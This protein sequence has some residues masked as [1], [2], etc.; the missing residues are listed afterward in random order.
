MKTLKKCTIMLDGAVNLDQVLPLSTAFLSQFH[1]EMHSYAIEEIPDSMRC[2][3]RYFH[4]SEE[5]I[6]NVNRSFYELCYVNK[7]KPVKS[8]GRCNLVSLK[9]G[10]LVDF[11]SEK[12]E[13]EA[14]SILQSLYNEYPNFIPIRGYRAGI[15]IENMHFP[16]LP[17]HMQYGYVY[18]DYLNM[19]PLRLKQYVMHINNTLQTIDDTLVLW[20]YGISSQK[21]VLPSIQNTCFIGAID[22][23]LG[24][25][26]CMEIKVISTPVMSGSWDTDLSE[27]LNAT[28]KELMIEQHVI[29]HINGADEAAHHK[30]SILKLTFLHEVESIV[31]KPLCMFC[32]EHSIAIEI[33]IDHICDANTGMHHKGK[34]PFYYSK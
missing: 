5:D 9:N 15:L 2:Y 1:K 20:P 23:L 16:G 34:T 8:C 3:L 26:Q 32:K 19:M 31:L 13:K 6:K 29:L 21:I 25:S 4:I 7:K 12:S 30:D 17:P 33:M 14:Y 10:R 27:K 28:M 24:V 18:E 11:T 22:A